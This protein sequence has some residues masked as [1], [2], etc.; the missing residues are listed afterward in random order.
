MRQTR[1]K[2]PAQGIIEKES[3][4]EGEEQRGV[5]SL[6][7]VSRF[8]PSLDTVGR[9]S[10]ER[11]S[12]CASGA[13]SFRLGKCLGDEGASTRTRSKL[14]QVRPD[15]IELPER[16]H[17]IQRVR[18]EVPLLSD[19]PH[20]GSGTFCI[21]GARDRQL[22]GDSTVERRNTFCTFVGLACDDPRGGRAG[23]VSGEAGFRLGLVEA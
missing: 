3:L 1:I 15:P 12:G 7:R 14:S 21:G 4:V 8:H 6:V 23:S 16:S 10:G 11:P 19:R 22:P 9:S 2:R 13:S 20:L 17:W 18:Y 5:R